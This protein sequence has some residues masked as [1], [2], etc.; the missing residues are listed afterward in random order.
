MDRNS[1]LFHIKKGDYF[2]SLA[3]IIYTLAENL[4][5]ENCNHKQIN[6]ILKQQIKDLMF[7]QKHYKITKN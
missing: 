5:K 3:C 2:G 6:K 4:E 1:L 7:L